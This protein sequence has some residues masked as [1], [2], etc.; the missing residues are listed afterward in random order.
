MRY[1]VWSLVSALIMSIGAS[2][3]TKMAIHDQ[4]W[5]KI[6]SHLMVEETI[7]DKLIIIKSISI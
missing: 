4:E 2:S 5:R 1:G 3:L 6:H 7:Q